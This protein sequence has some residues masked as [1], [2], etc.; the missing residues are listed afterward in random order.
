MAVVVGLLVFRVHAAA[1]S[2]SSLTIPQGGT[3]QIGSASENLVLTMQ[4]DGNLVLYQNGTA[5]WN[6]GTSGQNCGTNQCEAVFQSDG[7]FVVYNGATALW[8][9]QTSG[10]PGATLI[11]TDQLPHIEIMATNQSVLWA[12]AFTFSSA[13]FN[14]PQGASVKL[15]PTYLAMQSD[16]NLVMYQGSTA[17]WYTGTAANCGA[18]QCRAAFQSDGNFVVYNGSTPLWSTVTWG[19][20]W[21]QLALSSAAPFVQVIGVMTAAHPAKEYIYL[22]GKAVA[23]ENNPQ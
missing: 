7:N 10:N 12:N 16:G 15:G 2:Y 20:P 4:S 9:S 17:V 3:V 23:I 13:N 6:T 1:T 18:N 11:L 22:N 21:A 19:N 14:L 8:N 5:L